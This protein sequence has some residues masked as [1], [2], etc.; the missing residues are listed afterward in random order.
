MPLALM[1]PITALEGVRVLDVT[2]VMAGPFCTMMLADLGAD[3]IKVEPPG[4]D[5]TR[6]MPGAVGTDTPAYNAVNRGKRSVVLD[7]KAPAGREAI[8]RLARS[9][10]VFVE[11]SRPGAMAALG[12]DYPSLAGINPALIYASISGFGHTGPDRARGG[13]DLIAQGVSGIMSVTGAPDGP[14]MKSGVPLTDLAAALFA[15]TGILAA[16]IHRSRTGAGQHVDTS[17]VDAGV[18]LSVWEA[19]E[20]FAGAGVPE[21]LGSAHRMVAPYQAIRCADGYITIGASTDRT[22]ERLCDALGHPEWAR[23]TEFADNPSR[24]RHR[25]A[26]ADRIES[27][28]RQRPR[29]DWLEAFEAQGVP[30]GPIN[31]YDEVFADPQVLARE[32]VV[33]VEHPTLGRIRALGSPVKLSRTPPQVRRRAPLLGEHTEAVLREAGLDEAAIARLQRGSAPRDS[34]D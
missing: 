31:R 21:P 20:Y 26:L 5:M 6:R 32:M 9:A 2:Q 13:L 29:R 30:A 14:P 23:M 33:G 8:L 1:S 16:L 22:F 7:L 34:A 24:V 28:T 25:G 15:V 27:V 10:D 4:G 11:N 18:A 19:T 3:V 12:L 17:L